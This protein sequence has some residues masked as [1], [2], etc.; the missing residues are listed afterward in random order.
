MI[1]VLPLFETGR[2]DVRVINEGDSRKENLF[3]SSHGAF[4]TELHDP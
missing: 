2:Q 3:V 1:T 4:K